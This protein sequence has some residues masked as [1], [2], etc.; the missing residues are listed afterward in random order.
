GVPEMSP[1]AVAGAFSRATSGAKGSA[2]RSD[3]PTRQPSSNRAYWMYAHTVHLSVAPSAGTGRLTFQ[4]SDQGADDDRR[5]AVTMS[6]PVRA[7]AAAHTGR[8]CC[9]VRSRLPHR[10]RG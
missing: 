5:D 4:T 9:G 2:T 8:G 6:T 1:D 10:R 7:A 3:A